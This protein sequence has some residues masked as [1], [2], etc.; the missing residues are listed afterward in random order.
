MTTAAVVVQ[1]VASQPF[2][3]CNVVEADVSIVPA[4]SAKLFLRFLSAHT[5]DSHFGRLKQALWHFREKAP[6]I[7]FCVWCAWICVWCGHACVWCVDMCCVY[8]FGVDV[9][10]W[11]GSICVAC[12]GVVCAG[13]VWV[14]CAD[15]VLIFDLSLLHFGLVVSG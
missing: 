14:W 12:A 7:L 2:I 10:L 5:G 13:V 15:A 8:V 3:D 6:K 1:A 9:C 11:Y 4:Q